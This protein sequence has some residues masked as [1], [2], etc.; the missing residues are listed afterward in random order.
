MRLATTISAALIALSTAALAQVSDPSPP[1]EGNIMDNA[2]GPGNATMPVPGTDS[3]DPS[4][5]MLSN[6]AS[7]PPTEPK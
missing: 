1:P 2:S 5:N 3:N 6:S 7:P 4:R